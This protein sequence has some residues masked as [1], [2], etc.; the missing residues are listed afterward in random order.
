MYLLQAP[1]EK[2][3]L[4]PP[5][6]PLIT[7]EVKFTNNI[8]YC[9]KFYW[10]KHH[11]LQGCVDVTPK[12]M[13]EMREKREL[14]RILIVAAGGFGDVMWVMPAVKAIRK[15]HPR[16]K[17][18]IAADER[19]MPI[20]Q[21]FPYADACVSQ[22]FWNLQ[23]LIRI[24]DEVFDF[25]GIAT[26]FKNEMQLEPVEACF[27]HISWPLPKEKEDMRPHLVLTLDEGKAAEAL[28]RRNNIDPRKDKI[29]TIALESS[30]PNRDWPY[31]YSK[32]LT[33]S[34]IKDG[35]KV[36]WL[37]EKKD[38]GNTFSLECACGYEWELTTANP[39][40]IITFNCPACLSENE[41]EDLKHPDG[42]VNLGGKTNVRQALAVIALSDAFIGPCSGLMVAATA[43]KIPTVGI[44]GA[45]DSRRIAK[46][47]DKFLAVEG[48]APCKPC[49]DH[50]TECPHGHPAP[51]M[52]TIW[53][54]DVKT[55]VEHVIKLHPRTAIER[56]P[57][58]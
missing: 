56:I 10:R 55:A 41:V 19:T 46:Y 3:N 24:S 14:F 25:G 31:A 27:K 37:S 16:S 1:T 53:W 42:I 38:F 54:Q 36:V 40:N 26:M 50:W 22:D 2:F 58:E 44:F 30:T 49:K 12:W 39:P 7:D 51:C 33:K 15:K 45:F 47:Y 48:K 34:L 20:W 13:A 11:I 35:Y 17:I 18:L 28:L 43:L 6:T 8:A 21:S 57:I 5:N 32:T 52:K 4:L 29:I 9:P 23:N